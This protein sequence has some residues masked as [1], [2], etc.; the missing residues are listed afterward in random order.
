[1]LSGLSEAQKAAVTIGV[2]IAT[3]FV[4]LSIGRF[5]KRRAGVRFGVLFQLFCLTVAFY[6]AIDV[7][8]VRADWRNHVGS[9]FILLSTAFVVALVDRYIWDFYF[10]KMHQNPIPHFPR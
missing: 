6:A 4:A 2:F 9:I 3:F 5:L 1:M 10:D 8:G 7:E